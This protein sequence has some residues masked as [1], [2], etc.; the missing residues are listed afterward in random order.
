MSKQKGSDGKGSSKT[1]KE[2]MEAEALGREKVKARNAER[3]ALRA[4]RRLEQEAREAARRQEQPAQ[5]TQSATSAGNTYPNSTQPRQAGVKVRARVVHVKITDPRSN[6]GFLFAQA[7]PET[8]ENAGEQIY[9][10]LAVGREIYA[11]PWDNRPQF[12]ESAR[13]PV[14]TKGEEIIMITYKGDRGLYAGRFGLAEA[15]DH[16]AG[17]IANRKWYQAEQYRHFHGAVQPGPSKI[18]VRWTC[19]LNSLEQMYPR[20]GAA[21]QLR[22]KKPQMGYDIITTWKSRVGLNGPITVC[23]DPRTDV[24]TKPQLTLVQNDEKAA[25]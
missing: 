10:N 19:D 11:E 22:A 7:L 24:T 2:I 13:C 20:D 14:P 21:D 17:L 12:H 18:V 5:T 9:A 8:P 16:F 4:A 6:A 25:A 3:D 15:F 1:P 23:D